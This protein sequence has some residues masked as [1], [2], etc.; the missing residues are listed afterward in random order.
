MKSEK[1]LFTSNIIKIKISG[2]GARFI[3]H[4]N[5]VLLSLSILNG[6]CVNIHKS[7][8]MSNCYCGSVK[9]GRVGTQ[10]LPIFSN[11]ITSCSNM[12][13]P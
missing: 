10:P 9:I 7:N 4:A 6:D 12:I 11:F 13:Q 2:D 8:S 3:H 1:E 5:F